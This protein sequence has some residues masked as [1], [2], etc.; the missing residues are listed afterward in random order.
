M[1]DGESGEFTVSATVKDIEDIIGMSYLA[2]KV[3]RR[4]LDPYDEQKFF[5]QKCQTFDI[6]GKLRYKLIVEVTDCTAT[7]TF[8]MWDMQCMELLGQKLVEDE[9]LDELLAEVEGIYRTKKVACEDTIQSEGSEKQGKS[10][11]SK[12]GKE[13]VNE[14]A[15]EDNYISDALLT[16][17]KNNINT[18][19]A[20]VLM[21]DDDV[22][23]KL[24]DEFSSTTQKR[25]KRLLKK[26]KQ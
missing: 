12:K 5:C 8:R 9:V 4:E 13:Q 10:S 14:N 24:I 18:S 15:D 16:P 25:T 23:R 3:C 17:R 22:K 1:E 19:N 21:D 26:E 20:V 7:T 2:C 6:C 11:K